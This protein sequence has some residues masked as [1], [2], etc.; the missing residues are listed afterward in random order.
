LDAAADYL[1]N[2]AKDWIG[3]YARVSRPRFRFRHWEHPQ[4]NRLI[5]DR[6]NLL[7]RHDIHEREAGRSPEEIRAAE[8]EYYNRLWYERSTSRDYFVTQ[9]QVPALPDDLRKQIIAARKEIEDGYWRS[10]W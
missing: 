6:T 3:Q 5:A 10:G 2:P 7:E 8:L 4:L 1:S 9:G